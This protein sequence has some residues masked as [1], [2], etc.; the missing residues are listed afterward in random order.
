M[1][2]AIALEWVLE[3]LCGR[4]LMFETIGEADSV[5][6][7]GSIVGSEDWGAHSVKLAGGI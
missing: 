6:W 1:Q 7:I 4:M 2:G 3:L 5:A